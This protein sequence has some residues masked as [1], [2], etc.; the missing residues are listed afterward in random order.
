MISNTDIT[1][2]NRYYN[3]ADRASNWQRSVLKNVFYNET[4]GANR[5][6]TGLET[7][8][9]LQVLIPFTASEAR[10]F[11]AGKEFDN[12]DNPT[13][14]FTLREGDKIVKGNI[15]FEVAGSNIAA[16]EKEYHTFTITAVDTRD[17]GSAHMQHWEISAK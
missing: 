3:K 17:F 15:N 14:H 7:A 11:L 9:A 6:A 4:K 13:N 12:L 10:I 8:D 1:I 2:Y 16:L 5:R